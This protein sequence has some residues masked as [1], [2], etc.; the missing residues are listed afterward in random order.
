MPPVAPRGGVSSG[1]FVLADVLTVGR[2]DLLPRL[3][4]ARQT[5]HWIWLLANHWIGFA[6]NLIGKP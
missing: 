1:V 3:L 5:E 6:L 2:A 4:W